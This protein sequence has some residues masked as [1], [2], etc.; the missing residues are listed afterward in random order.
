MR[1]AYRVHFEDAGLAAPLHFPQTNLP[2]VRLAGG[3]IDVC[4]MAPHATALQLCLIDQPHTLAQHERRI[5][6][7]G[8]TN[9]MFHG[10]VPGIGVGQRYGFRAD[11]RWDPAAGHLYNP[12]K[13]LLDPYGRGLD[14][15]PVMSGA[16]HAHRT[17]SQL[18]PVGWPWTRD[19]RD[20]A[21]YMAYSVV[22]DEGFDWGWQGRPAVPWEQTVIMEGHVRGLTMMRE[23]IPPHL[24][25]TYAGVAH[26]A[27]I[28]HLK[29]LGVTA[30]ELLPIHASM[31]EPHLAQHGLTNYW[32]YS[33]LSYFAPNPRYATEAARAAGP[34]A[35]N[36]EVKGMIRLLHEAGIEVILDVVYNH[37]CEVGM[38]GPTVCWRGLDNLAWY[39]H[40]GSV[41]A[42]YADVT[43]TGNT[44][45]FRR[46][47]A[48]ALALDSLRHW[49]TEYQVDGFRYD[50]AVTLAR[51]YD[52][53]DSE[54]PFLV[55]LRSDPVLRQC[56]HIAEPW[57]VGPGGWQTGSFPVPIAAWNDSFRGDV[58]AFWLTGPK[59]MSAGRRPP[60]ARDVATRMSGSADLFASGDPMGNHGPAGSINFVTAH[61]GFTLRDLVAFDYKHNQPNGEN[62]RDGSDDNR[63]WNHGVEGLITD[64]ADSRAWDASLG[65]DTITALRQR[66]I[67]NLIGTLAL[68]AGVPMYCA[69]DEFGRTQWGN[70][71]AY[72]QDGPISWL[73]WQ[74]G[75]WQRDLV[76]TFRFLFALRR[77]HPVLRPGRFLTGA[78]TGDGLPDLGWYAFDGSPATPSQW[79]DPGFRQ[80]QMLRHSPQPAARDALV[81]IN[82]ALDGA[83]CVLAPAKAGAH[84]ELIWDSTWSEPEDAAVADG[85][86]GPPVARGGATVPSHLLSLRLYLSTPTEAHL[87]A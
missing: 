34:D 74:W 23:A 37:T 59:E 38:A 87:G 84:W 82:G 40:D 66:S 31:S 44:L 26:E 16:L 85:L 4:V 64:D 21:P 48:V 75:A 78:P 65:L 83:D 56:K 63:S 73:D 18:N 11:G 12:N 86:E 29:S 46:Q 47:M 57:D 49:V 15:T 36:R 62:N 22:T 35:V 61:D 54:H 39:L 76:K 51:T 80:V 24:R 43:G 30:L 1:Q 2:G 45:D 33:T 70:N 32:G 14:G 60:S 41:P 67:R 71:N 58:R 3:G 55:A 7:N 17:N 10:H 5:T 25:G 6:L 81:L 53:F 77:E 8:P 28:E 9:G 13:L 79:H 68:S 69:G 50:L 42:R 27:T 20:S 72:C 19:E 52:G